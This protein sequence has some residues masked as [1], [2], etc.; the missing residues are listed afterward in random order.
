M[1]EEN[2]W[3]DTQQTLHVPRVWYA[4]SITP[5]EATCGWDDDFGDDEGSFP[6]G[7]ELVPVVG[8]LDAP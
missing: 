3:H 4:L 7:R 5:L 8:L 6:K 1:R 2:V